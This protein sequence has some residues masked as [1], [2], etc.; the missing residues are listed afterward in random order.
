M[1][2]APRQLVSPTTIWGLLCLATVITTWVLGKGALD[3]NSATMLTFAI[4]GWK[5]RLVVR[6]FMELDQVSLP[7]RMIFEAWAVAA[8]VGIGFALV[9][10]G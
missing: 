5:I 9:I 3:A 7:R 10:L 1:N 4:V 8:P 6:R 2:A